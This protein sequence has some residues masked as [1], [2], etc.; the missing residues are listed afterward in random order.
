MKRI[1]KRLLAIA[2]IPFGIVFG[3]TWGINNYCFGDSVFSLLGIPSWSNG[4]TGTHYTAIVGS[5]FILVGIG[6]I[7]TTLH[8]KAWLWVWL[9]AIVLLF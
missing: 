5:I 9:I 6:V 1:L 3:G 4:T 8:K 2:A 7:C